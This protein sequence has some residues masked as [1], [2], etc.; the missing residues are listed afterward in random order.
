M[1]RLRG[2]TLLEVLI[3]LAIIAIGFAALFRASIASIHEARLLKEKTIK[4]WVAMQGIS[5]I[6]LGLVALPST[7]PATEKTVMLNQTWYWRTTVQPTAIPAVDLLK[8]T[9]SLN[10]EGPFTDPLYAFRY[11]PHDS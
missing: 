6:Q 9:V 5:M 8:V 10:P 1:T 2:F 7:T 11:L 3:A 4:H